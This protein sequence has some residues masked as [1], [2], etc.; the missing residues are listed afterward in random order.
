M[1]KWKRKQKKF[2]TIIST[3]NFQRIPIGYIFWKAWNLPKI[4]ENSV[5]IFLAKVSPVKVFSYVFVLL[6]DIIMSKKYYRTK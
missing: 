3:K 5:M 6:K 2:L 1:W 4:H